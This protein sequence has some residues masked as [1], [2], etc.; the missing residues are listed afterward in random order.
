MY[1]YTV[2]W[3]DYIWFVWIFSSWQ[4][5]GCCCFFNLGLANNAV[6]NIS[7]TCLGDHVYGD[8][9]SMHPG[10][11]LQDLSVYICSGRINSIRWLCENFN[12][13][14]SLATLGIIRLFNLSDSSGCVAVFLVVLICLLW[15]FITLCF[16]VYSSFVKYLLK[17]FAHSSVEFSA[18]FYWFVGVNFWF[19]VQIPCGVCV[20]KNITVTFWSFT[21]FH[22]VSAITT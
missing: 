6:T 10:V 4:G 12:C 21:V 3:L 5:F 1:E 11:E 22:S 13:S 15:C 2:V 18:L 7:H 9:L 20:L 8:W 17:P 16:H 14:T 19:W